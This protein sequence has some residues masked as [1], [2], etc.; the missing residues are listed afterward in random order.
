MQARISRLP[1]RE[2]ELARVMR[3]YE[4]TRLNYHS[5]LDKKMSADVAANMERR[6]KAERLV[7]LEM[8]RK[9]EM[10]IKPR[11]VLL[12]GAGSLFSFAL[13]LVIAVGIEAK[14]GMLLGEWELPPGVVILGRVP[15]IATAS[16]S[17]RL[18]WRPFVWATIPVCLIACLFG[19]AVVTGWLRF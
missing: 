3:D 7:M 11:K 12:F 13:G 6:Q 19:A 14:K 17:P 18:R 10:P 16:P 8:A 9:P 1:L 4:N 2:Q 15:S 5:M